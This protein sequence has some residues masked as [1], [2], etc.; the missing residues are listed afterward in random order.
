M[1]IF[2]DQYIEYVFSYFSEII[3]KRIT[4]LKK[5]QYN[6]SMFSC[7]HCHHTQLKWSGQCPHCGQWNTLHEQEEI[8]IAGK[9]KVTGKK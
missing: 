8:K 1:G 3:F 5:Y 4:Q 9:Q 7:T 2:F 6:T